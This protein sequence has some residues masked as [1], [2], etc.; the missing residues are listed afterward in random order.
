LTDVLY[1]GAGAVC[2]NVWDKQSRQTDFQLLGRQVLRTSCR[3][4]NKM[5]NAGVFWIYGDADLLQ[6]WLPGDL[7]RSARRT[8]IF[9]HFITSQ[10]LHFWDH[11][12][13]QHCTKPQGVMSML[14]LA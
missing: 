3:V 1:M 6:M 9:L 14:C 8:V 7:R 4:S 13:N 2:A 11:T 5:W 10:T 12:I